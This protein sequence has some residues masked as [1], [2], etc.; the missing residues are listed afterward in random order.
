MITA[1]GGALGT[2]KNTIE[3]LDKAC[4]TAVEAIEVDVRAD[5]KGN[6]ILGHWFIPPIKSRRISLKTVFEY[7]K[8]Y[9]KRV[10][11]DLKRTGLVATAVALAKEVGV[12]DL[13]YFTGSVSHD[14]I[15]DLGGCDV[16]V[17]KGFYSRIHSLKTENLPAIKAYLESYGESVINGI[18]INYTQTNDELWNKA[19]EIGLGVS[20]FTVDD[21]DVLKRVVK[22][23][24]DNI[25][26]N[27][28][29]V[30]L[31]ERDGI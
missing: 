2:R 8:K 15:K 12:E 11:V 16:Y 27:I 19:F 31:K 1:H 13:I 6:L 23:P 29:D 5:C 9:G 24:F 7:A 20:M 14:D 26:T 28:S 18:N 21:P 17:N 4:N 25:T 22:M 30:A 3:Y 10:N